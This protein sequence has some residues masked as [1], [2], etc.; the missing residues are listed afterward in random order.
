MC[1]PDLG[2]TGGKNDIDA[3]TDTDFVGACTL[4]LKLHQ[5]TTGL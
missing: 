5:V 1:T 4:A 2:F 3:D